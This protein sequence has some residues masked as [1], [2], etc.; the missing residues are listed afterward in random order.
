VVVNSGLTVHPSN[1]I[2]E[3]LITKRFPHS[4]FAAFFVK[5]SIG[6]SEQKNKMKK[7]IKMG[8]SSRDYPVCFLTC[9]GPN[10]KKV[11]G[12]FLDT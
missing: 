9:P 4:L 5:K 1:G 11:L 2:T 8:G 7:Y 12:A 10:L 6:K 3:E